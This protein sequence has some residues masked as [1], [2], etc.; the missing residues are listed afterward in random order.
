[1]AKL[2]T[3]ESISDLLRQLTS[4]TLG[5]ARNSWRAESFDAFRGFLTLLRYFRKCWP[6][7]CGRIIGIDQAQGGSTMGQ[8]VLRSGYFTQPESGAYT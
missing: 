8:G 1:M 6:L 4:P 7:K 3:Y 5:D 2:L